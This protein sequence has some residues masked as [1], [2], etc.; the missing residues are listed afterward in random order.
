VTEP[1]PREESGRGFPPELEGVLETVL[2]YAPGLHDEMAAFYGEVMGFRS[3]GG[4]ADHFLF[5][6][7]GGSVFLLFNTEAAARQDSP[8]PHGARGAGHVC[9]VV[10]E[11]A[12]GPWKRHLEGRGV[13]IED[14]LEWPRGGRSFYF[15]DPA[16]NAL[17]IADRDVWPG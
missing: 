16:G 3:V 1:G 2:Y 10:P 8:P 17:E 13:A 6:R 15:R 5:Y 4:S 7:A 12:Y 11:G 14:E 9:F